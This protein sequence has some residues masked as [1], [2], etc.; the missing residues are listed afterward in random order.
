MQVLEWIWKWHSHR[1]NQ[2]QKYMDCCTGLYML[3][4]FVSFS[5]LAR[6]STVEVSEYVVWQ[7]LSWVWEYEE[8]V[9]AHESASLAPCRTL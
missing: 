9:L 6:P 7:V 4:G 8:T 1:Q 5:L 3:V 2:I